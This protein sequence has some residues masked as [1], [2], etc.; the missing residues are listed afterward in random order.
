LS[1]TAVIDSETV[2]RSTEMLAG[3]LMQA[4]VDGVLSLLEYVL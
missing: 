3:M 2:D 4:C 1:S